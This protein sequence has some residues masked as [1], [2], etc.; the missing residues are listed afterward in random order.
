MTKAI[1]SICYVE[2]GQVRFR[3]LL[4]YR[5]F[6]FSILGIT[7]LSS[8]LFLVLLHQTSM[9]LPKSFCFWRENIRF[10]AKIGE[11]RQIDRSEHVCLVV[12][13]KK[14][15]MR[16]LTT[17]VTLI[18]NNDVSNLSP[19]VCMFREF[20]ISGNIGIL[21]FLS[22]NY[23]TCCTTLPSLCWIISR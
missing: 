4:P 20:C 7:L 15:A 21:S 19:L 12:P 1:F 11:R 2:E 16:L 14:E 22:T 10:Y 6:V 23:K 13:K 8:R 9:T 3:L 17:S 18:P 5:M